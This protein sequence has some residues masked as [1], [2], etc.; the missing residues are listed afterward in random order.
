[1]YEPELR[2]EMDALSKAIGLGMTAQEVGFEAMY[3]RKC[4]PIH[5]WFVDNVQ[6]GVDDCKRYEVKPEQLIQL[7]M[8]IKEIQE[9]HDRAEELLPPHSGMY[10]SAYLDNH[11]WANLEYTRGGIEDLFLKIGEVDLYNWRFEYYASW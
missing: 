1:M 8:T 2:A 10:G 11:Y 3:W 4:Y 6:G 7:A 5:D 9:N